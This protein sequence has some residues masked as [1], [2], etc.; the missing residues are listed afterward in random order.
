[1]IVSLWADPTFQDFGG[2]IFHGSGDCVNGRT[3]HAMLVG[4]A[5]LGSRQLI[6]A[7]GCCAVLCCA[8]VSP[9]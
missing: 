2:G 3:N 5:G 6:V 4:W 7:A 1:M 8:E 9:S